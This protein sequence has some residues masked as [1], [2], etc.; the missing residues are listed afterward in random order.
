MALRSTAAQDGMPQGEIRRILWI[1]ASWCISDI[2]M[3]K[4]DWNFS[5]GVIDSCKSREGWKPV[6]VG[7]FAVGRLREFRKNFP[8]ATQGASQ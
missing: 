4:V 3:C 7:C 6:E 2:V 5:N 1:V 8:W